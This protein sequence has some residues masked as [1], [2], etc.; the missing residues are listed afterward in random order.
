MSNMHLFLLALL[1]LGVSGAVFSVLWFNW[2]PHVSDSRLDGAIGEPL[3]SAVAS[4]SHW[5]VKMADFC[6]PLAGLALPEAGWESSGLRVRFMNAGLRHRSIPVL[7]F[8]TKAA[9]ALGFPI[10]FMLSLGVSSLSLP[11]NTVLLLLLVLASIGYYLPNLWLALRIKAYQQELFEAFP[12][13][14]DLIIVCIEAGL[15]LDAAI[16]RSGEEMLIRSPALAGEL[17]LTTLELRVGVSRELALHNLALRTGLEEVASLVT[18]L[19]QADRFGTSIAESLRVHA[20]SL[21]TRRRQKA[22]EAAAKI[23]LKILFPLIFCIFPSLMLVLLGP[24][25][26]SIYRVFIKS[27]AA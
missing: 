1:F 24:A 19:H 7:Y 10:I 9:L 8:A 6:R 21:R 3:V 27:V 25:A 14:M 18:M 15:G 11:G 16:A 26:I 5:L 17:H 13:A 22:E 12:D 23:P 2:R 4:N 20:E